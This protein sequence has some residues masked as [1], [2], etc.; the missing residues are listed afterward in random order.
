[1]TG[2]VLTEKK[3]KILDAI[4]TAGGV[5]TAEGIE[6]QQ[7]PVE[8]SGKCQGSIGKTQVP[9][10]R[11]NTGQDKC[12]YQGFLDFPPVWALGAHLIRLW[13]T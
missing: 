5:R 11:L 12:L 3:K 1:M 6:G 2:V 9:K 4:L 8:C 7:K 10:E 13:Y